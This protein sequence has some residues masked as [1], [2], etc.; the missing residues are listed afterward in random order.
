MEFKTQIE[1]SIERGTSWLKNECMARPAGEV[2]VDE[3]G[4]TLCM[5]MTGFI[6]E[7]DAMYTRS[8]RDM[9]KNVC[10]LTMMETNEDAEKMLLVSVAHIVRTC[11]IAGSR[12]KNKVIWNPRW[13][14]M[15]SK[16]Q[17]LLF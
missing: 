2:W 7:E 11:M 17:S 8:K 12:R 10:S 4:D 6:L 14:M 16:S 15:M 13:N 9:C 5:D 3:R 1:G